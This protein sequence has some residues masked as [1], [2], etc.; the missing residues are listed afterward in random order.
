MLHMGNVLLGCDII[1]GMFQ[2]R[3]A[4]VYREGFHAYYLVYKATVRT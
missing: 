3:G 4:T 2:V 1:D